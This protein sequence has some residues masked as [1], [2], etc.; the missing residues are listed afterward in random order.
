MIGTSCN[1]GDPCTTNDVYTNNC[2]CAGTQSPDSDN[3]G[4][5]DVLDICSNLD[6]SLLGQPCDDG[7]LCFIGSTYQ[8]LNGTFC[9]CTGGFFSDLDNDN[10]CDPL[11]ECPGFDDSIDTNNNGIPDGCEDCLDFLVE[12]TQPLI[13]NDQSRN[14]QITTNGTVQNGNDILYTAG[15]NIEMTARFEVKPGAVFHAKIEACN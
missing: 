8:V 11:D 6:D 4:V 13:T 2:N 15:N 9:S 3:D 1:D 5:C 7:I 12:N 10:V 14:I